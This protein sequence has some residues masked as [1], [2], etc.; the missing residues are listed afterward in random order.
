MNRF[1]V[2][3]NRSW[4]NVKTGQTASIYGAHPGTSA[5]DDANWL[6]VQNGFTIR[7]NLFNRV[8][9]IQSCPAGSSQ[10]HAEKVAE[11]L[12]NLFPAKVH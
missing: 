11:Q 4:R 8:G 2:I 10:E 12:N 3:P 7:D 5:A 9:G 1:E 6:V